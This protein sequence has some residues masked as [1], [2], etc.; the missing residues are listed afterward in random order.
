MIGT[1]RAA[2]AEPLGAQAHLGG[3][4]LARDVEDRVAGGAQ[5]AERA[6]GDRRLADARRAAEQ[7]ERAGHE[8][9][10]EHAVELADAGAQ[11]RDARRLDLGQPDGRQRL[12]GAGAA[13]AAA[14]PASRARASSTSVP[15]SSQPGQRPC[16]LTD[17]CP[18]AEQ[19]W[20]VAERAM[21]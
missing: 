1:L 21:H 11:A 5:V 4:L 9:A 12:A 15:H 8:A 20:V 14:P 3:R 13:A 19:T 2:G 18:Q 6:G 7:D 16:H 10:A 17:S